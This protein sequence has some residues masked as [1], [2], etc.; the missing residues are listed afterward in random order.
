MMKQKTMNWPR[1]N[2]FE[3]AAHNLEVTWTGQRPSFSNT[4]P[5]GVID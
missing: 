2:T 1:R 4:W 3:M 5:E